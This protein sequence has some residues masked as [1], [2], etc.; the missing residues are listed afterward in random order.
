VLRGRHNGRAERS[1][2]GKKPRIGLCE[3][4]SSE[5]GIWII[6]TNHSL[7]CEVGEGQ[8]GVRA[9]RAAGSSVA[10]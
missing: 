10:V 6:A 5:A 4:H 9:Q 1:G 2:S 8:G 3:L 7:P